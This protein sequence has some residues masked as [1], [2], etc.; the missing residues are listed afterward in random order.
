M[1]SICGQSLGPSPAP[2]PSPTPWIDWQ[3]QSVGKTPAFVFGFSG[4]EGKWS[5]QHGIWPPFCLGC[6]PRG[7]G[8]THSSGWNSGWL[9]PGRTQL[10]LCSDK[11]QEGGCSFSVVTEAALFTL[12]TPRSWSRASGRDPTPLAKCLPLRVTVPPALATDAALLLLLDFLVQSLYL[13][14]SALEHTW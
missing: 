10:Q 1:G 4:L 9:L 12:G 5:R 2:S 7:G 14:L 11:G 13:V 6:V 3:Q 8:C